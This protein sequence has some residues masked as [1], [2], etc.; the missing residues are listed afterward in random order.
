MR[1]TFYVLCPT[2]S[3]EITTIW[4]RRNVLVD[5]SSTFDLNGG[6][7]GWKE[8]QIINHKFIGFWFSKLSWLFALFCNEG[9][10]IGK[11]SSDPAIRTRT[12]CFV[13]TAN[14]SRWNGARKPNWMC[15][16]TKIINLYFGFSLT[17]GIAERLHAEWIYSIGVNISFSNWASKTSI[18]NR[19][20]F[21]AKVFSFLV[22]R[23]IPVYILRANRNE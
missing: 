7:V 9:K 8:N 13:V 18:L 12:T 1:S 3:A 2:R 15:L 22:V 23:P 6:S 20:W 5:T 11:R 10:F 17:C 19:K 14:Y 21:L 16:P 4:S